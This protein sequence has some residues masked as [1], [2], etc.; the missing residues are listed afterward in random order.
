MALRVRKNGCI[1]CAA[2]NEEEEGDLYIDDDDHYKLTVEMKIIV[3]EP[4][5]I[6]TENGGIWWWKNQVPEGVIID[7]FYFC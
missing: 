1:L 6:H 2:L 7:E 3:T 4:E 5:P